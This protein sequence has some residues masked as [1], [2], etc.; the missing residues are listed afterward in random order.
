M[1]RRIVASLIVAIAVLCS[2]DSAAAP[3]RVNANFT[4]GQ[5]RIFEPVMGYNRGTLRLSAAEAQ[6]IANFF[7]G[8]VAGTRETMAGKGFPAAV[9]V[10]L[11]HSGGPPYVIAVDA[12][13]TGYHQ[14]G[15][16]QKVQGD[17]AAF[18]KTIAN[19]EHTDRGP[20]G[21]K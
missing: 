21:R 19:P 7:P 4:D 16:T 18:L 13:L 6:E 12:G 1:A 17:L 8:M 14:G 15:P 9:R 20:P 2:C 11:N 5:V 3:P 10:T